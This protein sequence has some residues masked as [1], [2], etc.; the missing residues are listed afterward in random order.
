MKK[1]PIFLL[2]AILLLIVSC[3]N[4]PTS[5]KA[6]VE[7]TDTILADTASVPKVFGDTLI[8]LF[9]GKNIDTLI[10]EPLPPEAEGFPIER[11]RVYTKNHTVKD[12]TVNYTTELHFVDEGD[13]NG[14][15]CQ[16]WGFLTAWHTSN[17]MGYYVYTYVDGEWKQLIGRLP[18][19]LPHLWCMNSIDDIVCP[20]TDRKSVKIKYSGRE[21]DSIEG[22]PLNDTIIRIGNIID[23]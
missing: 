13:L 19:Y 2:S 14:D 9:N 18:I 21:P 7:D 23:L 15:G 3:K 16:E 8:G 20:T 6:I 17:W 4:T 11:W 10:S 22:F 5:G 1:L 12:L